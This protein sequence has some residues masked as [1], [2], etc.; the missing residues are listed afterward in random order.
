VIKKNK[1]V[2]FPFQYCL[3]N[4]LHPKFK[5]SVLNVGGQPELFES[6]KADLIN[7][8]QSH[9]D[10]LA[11]QE[12]I[13]TG[14]QQNLDDAMMSTRWDLLESLIQESQPGASSRSSTGK[15]PIQLEVEH[16]LDLTPKAGSIDVDV[17]KWW[18]AQAEDLP[19][20]AAMARKILA[21]PATSA[22]SE[23]LFSSGGNVVTTQRMCLDPQTVE[24]LVFYHDNWQK[25]EV[26]KWQLKERDEEEDDV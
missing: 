10:H 17:L 2:F 22:S 20:L 24:K 6:T 8:H 7:N 9:I 1:K 14:P 18:K 19:L 21:I 26:K 15:S 12:L 3:A 5:G 13:S 11:S 25:L 16:Y 4:F 23:R